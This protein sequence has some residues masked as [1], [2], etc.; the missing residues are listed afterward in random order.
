VTGFRAS[1]EP[2]AP[3]IGRALLLNLAVIGLAAAGALFLLLNAAIQNSFAAVEDQQ[4]ANHLARV[5]DYQK[6]SLHSLAARAKDWGIWDDSYVYAQGFG[7]EFERAN[8]NAES[9]AN[10]LVDGL[11]IVQARGPE[12]KDA[13]ETATVRGSHAYA[14][15]RATGEAMPGLARQLDRLVANPAFARKMARDGSV[16]TFVAL[17]GRVY[18]L[19]G[20]EI[21]RSDGS[22]TAPGYLVFIQ[23]FD[24]RELSEAVQLPARLDLE[25]RTAE[26]AIEKG[27]DLVTLAVPLP[28][29]DGKPVAAIDLK[30]KR[31]LLATARALLLLAFGGTLALILMLML[32]LNRRIG[33]LVVTP[34]ERLHAHVGH[35]RATGEL[36]ALEERPP[37][38]EL[39]ALQE[40]FNR[41]A[42][43]LQSLRGQLESQSF[44]LGKT[45]SAAGLMHNL[46]NSLSPVRVILE[47]L[48]REA[49]A[50]LPPLSGRALA[51]LAS[52]ATEPARR[53]KLAAFLAAAHDQANAKGAAQRQQVREAA[54]NLMSA[55]AA[56]DTA[57]KD[58]G[59]VR[60]DE[61]C[62]LGALLSHA[63]NIA[64]FAGGGAIGVET[65]AQ[66]PIAASG[67]RVLLGQILEN[68]VTNAVEAVH[69]SGR[70]D[71]V[72][73]LRALA[74]EVP[75]QCR[76]V[77]TDN[78]AGFDEDTARRL[79]ERGFSTRTEKQGGL[80]LHWCANIV[81]AMSGDLMLDSPGKGLGARATIVLPLWQ[82]P[83]LANPAAA[84]GARP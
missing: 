39:G 60:Y 56:I 81:K 66:G 38:N 2:A 36:R 55:L 5:A 51:E 61:R 64:R 22:G 18:T 3:K 83:A 67:N 59:D 54:R 46:R 26:V 44:M 37:P 25:T 15:D 11:A 19:A 63:G 82:E 49:G 20:V 78:G 8:V 77:I 65:S 24:S 70:G 28:G 47:T 7:K 53:E 80:G 73:L 45:Q 4:F 14:F 41:M 13:G 9:F 33:T 62:D 76:I 31:P 79:F 34:I 16:A 50:P 48:E 68:L 42:T 71:G 10:A 17:D 43:E 32:V 40:E 23:K 6:N 52:D 75:G 84:G 35:I 58:R 12:R 30:V 29:M 74:D 1:A 21:H 27:D 57:Q 69:E 72:V